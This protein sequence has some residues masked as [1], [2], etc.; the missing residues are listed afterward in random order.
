MV[1]ADYSFYKESYFGN[2]LEEEDFNR[3]SARASSFLDYYTMGKAEK[4]SGLVELKMACC[5]VAEHAKALESVC[6]REAGEEKQSESVGSYSVSYRNGAETSES[7]RAS[8][9]AVARQYL[10]GTGLLYRG[11]CK[12]V[13]SAR[14]NGL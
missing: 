5:A 4:N 9:A 8:M 2:F 1:Y 7:V 14:S 6:K 12:N 13:C 10:A 3:L 11:G